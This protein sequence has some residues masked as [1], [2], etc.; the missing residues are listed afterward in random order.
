MVMKNKMVPGSLRIVALSFVL[1]SLAALAGADDKKKTTNTP[2]PPPTRPV[3]QQPSRPSSPPV[4]TAPAPMPHTN[5]TQVPQTNNTQVPRTNTQMPHTGTTYNSQQG[6]RVT[7][8]NNNQTGTQN[9]IRNSVNGNLQNGRNIGTGT[10]GNRPPSTPIGTR[11]TG[12]VKGTPIGAPLMRTGP[13]GR[14]PVS[15]SHFPQATRNERFVG[16]KRVSFDRGGHMRDIHARGMEVHRTMNHQRTF[17]A[18]RNG[19]RIVG[20]GP[21]RGYV[22]RVYPSRNGRVYVQRT[23]VVGGVRY[24]SVYRSYTWRGVAY[25]H[26]VPAYY[27]RPAFY[28]WAYSPWSVHIAW[29]WGWGGAPWYGYYGY[30]FAPYPVY[31]APSFW[32]TDYV[33]AANLQLAYADRESAAGNDFQGDPGNGDNNADQAAPTT[34]QL[35][36]EVKQLIADEV[37]RQIAAERD[38]AQSPQPVQPAP[39]PGPTDS[40]SGG[41]GAPGSPAP[42]E[43][44]TVLS[45]NSRVFIVSSTLDVTNGDGTECSLTAGDVI[46]R[47]SDTPDGTKVGVNVLT[48]KRG[49]CPNNTNTSVDVSDLQEM[50]NQFRQQLD[51]GLKVLSEDQGK[52]G[53]PSAPDTTTTASGAPVAS[54]DPS[55]GNDINE[56]QKTADQVETDVQKAASP[57]NPGN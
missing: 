29:G 37:Q 4:H 14:G 56:Q 24:A 57:A 13:A 53:M 28:G 23:Y 41:P 5:N 31:A 26:Y 10:V 1:V 47:T 30:Y 9:G 55:A 11:N 32:L 39:G 33:L 15:A 38:A 8:T 50:Q 52:N 18:E 44:P 19:R 34:V 21:H 25:Y 49:D 36:P 16:D 43:T 46:L 6:N 35:S 40:G 2:P 45:P 17:V 48:S 22:Q 12:I 3:Q 20:L 7:G 51:S 42:E 27:Y 54:P